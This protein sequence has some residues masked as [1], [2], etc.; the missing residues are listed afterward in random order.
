VGDAGAVDVAVTAKDT[1]ELGAVLPALR[2]V[3][4]APVDGLWDTTSRLPDRMPLSVP[5][6]AHGAVLGVDR[7]APCSDR[8]SALELHVVGGPDAGR[9]LPLGRGRHVLG[10]GSAA[11]VSLDDPDVSRSHVA[12]DVAAGR[13]TVADLGSTNGTL[14]DDELLP[15]EPRPWPLGGVLRVGASALTLAG[16][17]DPGAGTAPGPG[18]RAVLGPAARLDAPVPTRRPGDGPGAT[19]IVFPRPPEPV[20]PRRLA[21]VAV[22]LP[23]VGGVLMAWLLDA[24]T[25]LFFALLSPL[26]AL[27][28]WL[29]DRWTGRRSARREAAAHAERTEVAEQRL[30]AAV[31]AAARAADAAHPDLASLAASARRRTPPLWSRTP[32][33]GDAV[34]VR[35]GVGPRATGV[36]RVGGEG[37]R[38]PQLS[39]HLPV[40]VDLGR[41]GGLDVVG[42]RACAEGVVRS[43]LLQLAVLLPP[44]R[45]DLVLVLSAERVAG[46]RWARWLPHVGPG[47]VHVSRVGPSSDRAEEHLVASLTALVGRH[48][49]GR[50]DAGRNDAGRNDA[51][52]GRGTAHRAWT[53]VVVD[54]PVGRR[55]AALLHDA[56]DAGVL[57]LTCSSSPTGAPVASGAALRLGGETG[58]TGRLHRRGTDDAALVSVD[59]L[60]VAT[61]GSLARHLAGLQPGYEPGAI[62]STVRLLDL[63]TPGLRIDVDDAVTGTWSRRRDRL[64][65][66]LGRSAEGPASIDLCTDGPHA[67]VAGTTGSGKSELLQSLIA[68]LALAHP[69]GA[70]SFLLVD[71]KGGAAF[72]EAAALPHTVG[73]LTD[74][75]G[76]STA[77]ALRSLGAELARRERLLASARVADLAALP[78]H[79]ELARLVIV[80]DEFAT[81]ADELPSFVPGLIGIAQRGRSLGVHL[82]LATQRPAGVVS[83]EIKANCSLRICLRTTDE[84]DSRDVLGT[85]AAARLPVELPGR[86]Y[87]RI[88]NGAPGLVQVAR[89]AATGSTASSSPGS[90]APEVERWAWPAVPGGRREEQPGATD[91][92]R[93]SRVL[94][95][96]A[97]ATGAGLPHRPWQP[98]LPDVVTPAEL[99]GPD[100][101]AGSLPRLVLGLVDLPD[102]QRRR[103]LELDLSDGGTWLAVGGPRSGRSTLLRTVLREAVSRLPAEDLHV[104]LVESGGGPL[105]AE[106]A[107]LPH[108]GTVISGEDRFRTARLVERL[109]EEI[110]SRR[111]DPGAAARPRIL[112]LIDGV[113]ELGVLLEEVLPGHGSATL[114]R[115][116]RDGAAAGLTCVATADRAVPGGRLAGLAGRRLVLPLADAA[117]YAVAGVPA[118]AV[119]GHRP[120]GRA[121]IGEDARECQ[122]ALPRS[123]WQHVPG[124]ARPGR[125]PLTIAVLPPD[126]VLRLDPDPPAPES[127]GAALTLVIGPGGDEGHPLAVDLART[128]GLL[129]AGPPGSGRSDSLAAFASDLTRRGVR[130][131]RLGRRPVGPP[132]APGQQWAAPSDEAAIRSW[133]EDLAGAPGVAVLDDAGSP[134]ECSGLSALLGTGG[135]APLLVAAQ[136]A[137]LAGHFQGP[138]AA[139]RR[140]RAGLLL[141][142]APGDADLLGVRL[143]RTP[144]PLRPGSGWLVEGGTVQRVQ[145][146]RRRSAAGAPG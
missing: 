26:V 27:G 52:G 79:V 140:S 66:V 102:R 136:P 54:R 124:T 28:T 11:T 35:L 90:P 142:P 89:V 60:A 77:R 130:L 88:G 120:P 23:A 53:V 48:R 59:R 63:P 15:A 58:T 13:I 55:L 4:P 7:P 144:L 46:W 22:A 76:Q 82:V 45:L 10:R 56:R 61:A 129:V 131:L 121:L 67:L 5:G 49:T 106:L 139:L 16:P 103:T 36:V 62:P 19:E 70:C 96:H 111:A 98:P 31:R 127:P 137:D 118:R 80:V 38:V 99:E 51:A 100:P 107:P 71:Y 65:A 92:A 75:D 115:V 133:L 81:L 125:V 20:P 146:A 128:G 39:R 8:G 29:S 132:D 1:D 73:V 68:G 104:H 95:R 2:K 74:L 14:L 134:A 117:D 50:N 34:T 32:G 143:P 30:A 97:A 109:G 24:P 113:D 93:V 122:L 44:G 86:A 119:P 114:G 135:R 84:A 101:D 33:D 126:P 17:A 18:G 78:P 123:P 94:A 105:G 108:A 112:L 21:W 57:T 12:V 141:R 37:T 6:L 85:S 43:V 116:L 47:S 145:V 41:D 72:A 42:P 91:L 110:A 9:T 83:P 69:P 25:F 138:V 64:R 40:V 3:L 87:V